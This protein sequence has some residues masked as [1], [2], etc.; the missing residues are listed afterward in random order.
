MNDKALTAVALIALL[1]FSPQALAAGQTA[2]STTSRTN[3]S[4]FIDHGITL[5]NSED[6]V[7]LSWLSSQT[8]G[9]LTV[10]A[11]ENVIQ[12]NLLAVG[13]RQVL[14]DIGWQNYAVGAVQDQPWV[15]NWLTACD[16]LG[17]QNLLYLGQLTQGGYDSTWAQS[18]I[19]AD[20]ST[21]TY[22]ADGTAA[23]FV[24]VDNA[25]VAKAIEVDLQTLYSY[26]GGHTS[27]VG[28]G[29]GYPR[30]DP[31]F[32]T[33]ATMPIMGYSNATLQAFA[34][35]P[36]F[37]NGTGG[38]LS[39]SFKQVEPSQSVTSGGWMTSSGEPVY[40][41]QSSGNRVAMKFFLPKNVSEMQLSWYGNKVGQAGSLLAQLV[42]DH[43]GSL[44]VG[45]ATGTA[46]QQASSISV[47]AGWQPSLQF[48]GDF[49]S[50]NYWVVF[51]SPSSDSG[52]YVTVYMRDYQVGNYVAYFQQGVD[53]QIG[54][55]TL[56]I[57]DGQGMDLQ[58]YPYQNSYIP[59]GAQTFA[60]SQSFSFNTVFLFLSDRDYNPTNGTLVITDITAGGTVQATGVL[61][62]ALTHGLQNWTPIQLDKVVNTV[63]GDNYSISITEPQNGYSWS[64]VVRGVTTDPA[65]AGFQGQ[66]SYWLFRLDLMTWSQPHF[67][68]S[69][70]TS[71]GADDVRSGHLDAIQF[72][73]SQNETLEYTSLLMRNAGT[74]NSTY[75]TGSLTLGVWT[76]TLN[77]SQPYQQL[78]SINITA[79]KIPENGWLNSSALHASLVGGD[80]YWLVISTNSS[81]PFVLARLTSPYQSDVLVSD[82]GGRT[83]AAP[84][85][86]PSEYSFSLIL[87]KETLGPAV[88]D[89]PQVL[90]SQTSE[91]GQPIQVTTP[92]Q[93]KGV[94]LGVFER[95]SSAEPP[96]DHILVSIHPDNG[97]GKPSQTSLA[98]GVYYGDNITFYSPDYI[99]FTTVARLSPGQTYWIVVQPVGGNYYIFPDV[100][101]AR[102]PTT[103]PNVMISNDA[104]FTWQ[105]YS[106]QTTTLSYM[107]ASPV[108]PS[109][110]Y[111]TTQLYQDLENLHDF[112]VGTTPLKGWP[113]YVQ[114]SEL[115]LVN[116]VASWMNQETGRGWEVAV[117]A[118]PSVIDAGNYSAI[119]PLP[120]SNPYVTC[121]DSEQYLLTQAPVL[122][123]QLYDVGNLQLLDSCTSFSM[124][125][126]AQ[127]LGYLQ[128][129]PGGGTSQNTSSALWQTGEGSGQYSS[130]YYSISGRTGGP[131]V[132]WVSNAGQ[133][134]V[135]F[136]LSLNARQLGLRNNW[137]V[138][139]L[140][141]STVVTGSGTSFTIQREIPADSW[142]PMIVGSFNA[143]F[144]A[145]YSD[146]T[147]QRQLQYPNQGLYSTGASE[148]QSVILLISSS[149]PVG[150]VSV[151]S[152]T[153][154]TGMT[155]SS[156]YSSHEGWYYD[157]T[158]GILLAKYQSSGNDTVRV[159]SASPPAVHSPLLPTVELVT[160]VAALFA[161]DAALVLY[162]AF[163]GRRRVARTAAPDRARD[164]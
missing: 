131:I 38:L 156:F 101:L 25:D 53:K 77:G 115:A 64:V 2:H 41:S 113:A 62:Q 96:N 110:T 103:S 7:T 6:R 118:Q 66:A 10:P 150:G 83:W 102:A 128:F 116:E 82:N 78:A 65:K 51:S 117:S 149:S 36:F 74:A 45:D 71:N 143:T 100:Y 153:N 61:S 86:G 161:I 126:F 43:N 60:T 123:T 29:T 56:W 109:P 127:I 59:A 8:N 33:N 13:V 17:V 157:A 48:I 50:G 26:Y 94:Y 139:G 63:P 11:F 155:A 95:Q 142:Y 141:N 32:P 27:W 112:P 19:A 84:A 121:A 15:K 159:L 57:R 69:V 89:V 46:T 49:V 147:I 79:S 129:Y 122:N 20:P 76:S 104:G 162:T 111:N 12:S 125:S 70:I 68:Y 146:A 81:S 97:N 135:N 16:A 3:D 92:T 1:A 154:L 88:S 163:A 91:L 134:T 34:N 47:T 108:Q 21:Q 42:P 67:S 132:L 136:S 18:L 72:M 152:K 124:A 160:V 35:S 114:Y 85:E 107:L 54:Y 58:I 14:L 30:S 75:S 164:T 87:S 5:M 37:G 120:A 138:L 40:G 28:I 44:V 145:S 93:V 158:S 4:A 73:P 98:S 140:T 144:V 151:D 31:Y 148:N 99:Q 39:S 55:T 22:F 24:S 137:V 106:N 133:A 23:R 90:L 105:R 52:N 80:S 119:T 9:V 130:L